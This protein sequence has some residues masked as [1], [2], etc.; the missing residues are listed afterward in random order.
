MIRLLH[1]ADLHLGAPF[2]SL[3]EK[4]GARQA[5]FL[6]TFERLLTAAI[7]N[8]VD[9]FLVAGDLFDS[10]RPDAALVG[11]V[12]AGLKRL[13]DRGII[14]VLLP[15]THDNVVAADAVYR[16]ETFPGIVLAD[17]A[18]ETP[19]ALQVR[20]NSVFLYGF[21]YRSSASSGALSGMVRRAADGVHI[22]LLHGS[23]QGSPEW[24]YR[25]KDLP[26]TLASLR[27]WGL[28]YVA[29]GHYHGFEVL[30]EEGRV[31]ACYPGSPEGKRFGENGPRH[32]ALVT[33]AA[34]GAQVEKMAV[35]TLTL[36]EKALDLAGCETLEQA[37]EGVRAFGR[38][39]LL[40]RLGLTGI[41]ESPL[42]LDLLQ[43]RC[44]DA[45]F[46]LELADRTRLFD[47]GFAARIEAEETVRGVFVRR[48]RQLL[49]ESPPERRPVVE[50]A[51]RE[52][53]VRFNA[54]GPGGEK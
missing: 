36:E 11:R 46:H 40:L 43:A 2:P 26:F 4:A 3:G 27:Q 22:G 50:E 51:F 34:G 24:E 45:F 53:L 18:V 31:W 12:Q 25:R 8:E 21:A 19:V 41:V 9:L 48:A 29:L 10:P 23:R 16:R 52:V 14:P 37:V 20:G 33:V 54:F 13:A 17:P 49:A 28:D 32:A 39:D 6:K 30:E 42:D 47:S 15:G 38:A 5:A 35:N 44:E 7:K 1:T